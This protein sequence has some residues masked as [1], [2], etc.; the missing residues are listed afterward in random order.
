MER[1]GGHPVAHLVRTVYVPQAVVLWVAPGR[2]SSGS[3]GS[4]R[5]VRDRRHRAGRAVVGGGLVFEAVGDAQLAAFTADPANEGQVMDRGLWRYTRHPNYFGDA[6]VWWGLALHHAAGLAGLLSAA[7]M[8][9]LAKGTGAALLDR[10]I[11]EPAPGLR[12]VRAAHERVLPAAAPEDHGRVRIS[13]P[14]PVTRMVCSNWAVRDRSRV[15]TVQSSAHFSFS[16]DPNVIIGS[17]VNVIP[18][19]RGMWTSG[20]S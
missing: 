7:L 1:A 13:A 17:M 19:S 11:R 14:S 2:C 9:W 5:G 6:A 15:T 10:S 20:S 16:L 8:T 4:R 12:G 18:G 3:P